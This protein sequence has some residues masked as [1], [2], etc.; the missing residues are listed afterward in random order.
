MSASPKERL[1]SQLSYEQLWSLAKEAGFAEEASVDRAQ[2][3][4]FVGKHYGETELKSLG[5]A[6][7]K[8]VLYL[9]IVIL[10]LSAVL[11]QGAYYLFAMTREYLSLG[12]LVGLTPEKAGYYAA[13][14]ASGLMRILGGAMIAVSFLWMAFNLRRSIDIRYRMA[15]VVSAA[16]VLAFIVSAPY[17]FALFY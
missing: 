9:G 7:E 8:K 1:L 12:Q 5:L 10:V 16:V 2:L 6:K 17:P 4:D 15:L 11:N 14:F 13:A 3:A